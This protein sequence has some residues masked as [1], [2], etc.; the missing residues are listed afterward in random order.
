VISGIYPR[1]YYTHLESTRLNG[2]M[3]LASIPTA[4]KY[5]SFRAMGGMLGSHRVVVDNCAI[6][7][8]NAVLDGK[9]LMW[10]TTDRI[11]NPAQLPAGFELITR[12]DNP[13]IPDRPGVLKGPQLDMMAQP[14]SYFG[15][16]RAVLHDSEKPP[17]EN[18][19][20]IAR[21]G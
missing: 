7:E 11:R 16:T 3:R 20:Y 15:I 4:K 8:G 2:A 9:D 21:A 10:I 17:R 13:R 18:L 14:H 5:L 1:G 12:F 19:R 6:G